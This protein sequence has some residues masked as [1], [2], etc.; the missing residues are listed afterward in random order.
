M[1]NII[2]ADYVEDRVI[3]LVF[4]DNSFGDYDLK[5][6]IDKNTIMVRPFVNEVFFKS[7]FIELGALCWRNGFELSPESL[8]QKLS[9]QNKLQPMQ[10]VA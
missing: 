7:F 9:E 5:P 6:L 3:R 10:K 8:H 4:S 1:I 2:K